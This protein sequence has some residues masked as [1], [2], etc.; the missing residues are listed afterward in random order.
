M[1]KKMTACKACGAEIAKNAKV[2][3]QCG[4]KNKRGGLVWGILIG[5][6]V[7]IIIAAAV[8]GSD[9][10][11]P[12]PRP[13][14]PTSQSTTVTP[15]ANT[16]GKTTFGVGERAE[17]KNVL[18]TLT[19]VEE[20]AGSQFN[21][22]GDGNV[23]VLCAFEIENNSENEIAVSS[24]MS[25]SAYCDSYAT[26]FSLSALLEKGNKNQLDGQVAA[27]KKMSGVIGYEV[28]ADWKELEISFT[29]DFWS[30]KEI[31]FVAAHN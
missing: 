14:D 3:P 12:A 15:P 20:S 1:D 21:K 11:K 29:P 4:A 9:E 17:L 5:A 18:V 31:T 25:F 24:L 19:G 7:L 6:L 28:P 22:P 30:G 26:N 2:C 13:T 16:A 27:G 10:P 23:F 8:G